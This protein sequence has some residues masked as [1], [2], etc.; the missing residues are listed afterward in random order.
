MVRFYVS[1]LKR[2]FFGK[3]WWVLGGFWKC[4]GEL[5]QLRRWR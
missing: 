3:K 5:E 4:C 1:F 2:V